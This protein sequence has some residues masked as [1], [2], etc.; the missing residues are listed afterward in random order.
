[1][2]KNTAAASFPGTEPCYLLST[3]LIGIIFERVA[4][5]I[6]RDQYLQTKPKL[7]ALIRTTVGKPGKYFWAR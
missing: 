3:V 6:L 2:R 5:D 4:I 7:P 1:M